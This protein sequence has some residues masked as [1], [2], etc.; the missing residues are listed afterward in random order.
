MTERKEK[1]HSDFKH[2][3]TSPA[4]S[5]GAKDGFGNHVQEGN[6]SVFQLLYMLNENNDVCRKFA[7]KI[8]LRTKNYKEGVDVLRLLCYAGSWGRR[9]LMLVCHQLDSCV[10][11][12]NAPR[13]DLT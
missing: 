9:H 11:N 10:H 8:K 2:G 12:T 5:C 6:H 4:S 3:A 7:V 13:P 1:S